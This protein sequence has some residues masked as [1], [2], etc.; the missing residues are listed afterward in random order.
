MVKRISLL[1]QFIKVQIDL[2]FMNEVKTVITYNSMIY[3]SF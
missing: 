1:F 2:Y 3:H